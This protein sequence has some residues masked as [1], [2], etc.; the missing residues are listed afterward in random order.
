MDNGLESLK[1]SQKKRSRRYL[2]LFFAFVSLLVL[3]INLVAIFTINYNVKTTLI[4]CRVEYG[5]GDINWAFD[6]SD[7]L[8][9]LHN[10]KPLMSSVML[11]KMHQ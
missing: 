3:I 7:E 2:I 8:R 6:I 4:I 1:I 5:L 11:F 10:R 9:K